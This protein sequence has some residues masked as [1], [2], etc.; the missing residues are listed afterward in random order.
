MPTIHCTAPLARIGS[1]TILHLPKSV[2]A[3]LPTRGMTVV[4]GTING[5]RFLAPLEPDGRGSHWFRWSK[6]MSKATDAD[7]GD[8]VTLAME[9]TKEWPEPTVPAD[10]KKALA[11]APRAKK[12]WEDITPSARWDWIRWIRATKEPSTRARRIRVACS[13]LKAGERR[14]CCFNRNLCTE[15]SVSK[16]GVLLEPM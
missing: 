2:S 6:T 13:K 4:T 14:P 1:W 16:N 5:S 15:P 12:L 3:K 9:S 10:V 11:L 7:T 8:T